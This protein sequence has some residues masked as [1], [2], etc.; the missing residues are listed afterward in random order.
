MAVEGALT[1]ELTI[2]LSRAF[3]AVA[4]AVAIGF[5]WG[6]VSGISSWTASI[7]QPAIDA[8]MAL[9]PVILV[10]LGL[11]WFGPGAA[12][13]R[14][15]II[16]VATPLITIAVREAVRNV[17]TD[18]LEMATVF[19]LSRWK[20]LRHI[21][22]PAIASPALAAITV[23]VGQSLR[24]AVMAELLSAADGVGADIARARSHLVTADVFAWAIVLVAVVVTI[25]LVILRP[26]TNRLLGW[27]T[28]PI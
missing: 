13:T 2:T 16:L 26:L 9:P 3:S 15:V 1:E 19:K 23:I 24:L 5:I 8:L 12:T 10:V 22:T 21:L 20:I 11:T 18:L 14:L 17:D 25:E 27:R 28:A 4:I 6:V 7:S